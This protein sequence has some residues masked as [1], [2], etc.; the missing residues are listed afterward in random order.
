MNTED[1]PDFLRRL[2]ALAEVFDVKLS[3][4]RSALYF[5]ALRDLPMASA[6]QALNAAVKGCKFFPRPVEL[7][8]FAQGNSDDAAEAAWLAFQSAMRRLGA[9]ASVSVRD[10]ALAETVLAMFGS[11][12]EACA[13]ELSPEMWAA[14]RKEFG[15]TYRV[16]RGRMLD[17]GRY[18]MGTA[19]RHNGQR[20]DWLRYTPVGRI[21][22][23]G[24][25]LR[26]SAAEAE[27]ERQ[28]LAA[29]SN[30]F[31]RLDARSVMARLASGQ[32][33]DGAA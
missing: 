27:A 8:E 1:Q 9:M 7:R 2:M 15:R 30:E 29:A 16:M 10:A 5:E 22:R 11:W 31:S 14:K 20:G 19:E 25:V 28:Q 3:P 33:Q 23:D 13:A 12:P 17:G 24:T 21:D 18:L 4:A 26:L 6:M 32:Q